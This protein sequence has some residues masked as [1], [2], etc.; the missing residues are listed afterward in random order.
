MADDTSSPSPP[1]TLPSPTL[2]TRSP[3]PSVSPSIALDAI[4]R[5]D[6]SVSTPSTSTSS[7]LSTRSRPSRISSDGSTATV[8]RRR[9]YM[10]PQGTAFADSARNRDSV[11]SLGS[12]AHMQYYFA[13]TGLLD[14]KGGQLAKGERK[15][16]GGLAAPSGKENQEPLAV[17]GGE[18]YGLGGLSVQDGLSSC[19]VSESGL[20]SPTDLQD[21]FWENGAETGVPQM[22]PPTVSTYKLKPSY[23]EP[24]PDM[25]VLR[26]E[27]KEALQD[28]CKVLEESQKH[29]TESAS[30]DD[31]DGFHEIQGLHVLDL[32][33]LAIRAAKNYYTAHSDHAKLYAIKSEKD[34]RIHNIFYCVEK[35]EQR[36]VAERDTWP[37]RD[38]DW[39]GKEQEREWLFLKSFNETGHTLP[40]WL[41]RPACGND[42]ISVTPSDFLLALQDGQFLIQLHNTF[43]ARSKRK[44]GQIK[45]WHTDVAKPYRR[46]ENLRYWLKAAELRFD[47]RVSMPVL[48]VVNGKAWDAFDDAILKWSQGIRETLM[49]ELATDAR[50][51]SV[52]ELHVLSEG[53]VAVQV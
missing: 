24:L 18:E 20:E 2:R 47:V 9:G 21:S 39:T 30:G 50:V 6:R 48:D 53:G 17:A 38:G 31:N 29:N 1:S 36:E 19:G 25:P 26:R 5:L 43:V 7:T 16:S 44:F 10:R 13:R 46:A 8:V 40:T 34:L 3:S 41:E 23:T 4:P 45:S 22:L 11:M 33:T 49:R 52:P 35:I 42:S 15:V 37:W 12:I 28:A 14:G 27:L 32:L 51:E